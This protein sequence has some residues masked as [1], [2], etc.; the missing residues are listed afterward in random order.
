M[1]DSINLRLHGVN[2][3][4]L[5][6]LEIIKAQN[7]NTSIMKLPEHFEL[8]Q[9]I[10][11][12]KG[13][14]FS[15][16]KTF[17]KEISTNS[18]LTDEEFLNSHTSKQTHDYRLSLNK[19]KFV[20]GDIEKIYNL[21]VRGKYSLNSQS[22]HVVFNVNLNAGYIDFFFSIPKYLYSHQ[23]AQFIPQIN[24]SSF[25]KFT[26][27]LHS[28]N[29]Q[30]KIL[31]ERLS[32]FIDSFFLDLCT[33]FKVDTLPN[34]EYIEITRLDLCYNQYFNSKHDALLY[35]EEQKKISKRKSSSKSKTENDE[36][37]S[38]KNFASAITIGLGKGKYFKIY[39]KGSEYISSTG[40]YKKHRQEN[41]FY[42]DNMQ[43]YRESETF[44]NHSSFIKDYFHQNVYQENFMDNYFSVPTDDFIRK[45][46]KLLSKHM[47]KDM[48]FKTHFYK[49]E[50]DK[51]L[52]YELSLSSD[53]VSRLY[54]SKVFRKSCPIHKE[55]VKIYNHVKR[56]DNRKESYK[57]QIT[58][59]E[60]KIY[61]NLHQFYSRKI[62]LVLSVSP[63]VKR[64]LTYGKYSYNENT[65]NYSIKKIYGVL[66]KGSVLE[67]KDIGHFDKTILSHMVREFKTYIN[68]FQVKEL[69]PYETFVTQ[70]KQFN[71]TVKDRVDSYN[72]LHSYKTT[73]LHG[74]PIIKN[75]KII[76]YATELLSDSKKTELGLKKI[77]PIM[78]FTFYK[79][80]I[81]SK[82]TM[83][84]I[85]EELG[86]DKY[87]FSR[88]KK[89][90]AYFNVHEQSINVSLPIKPKTDFSEYYFLTNSSLYQSKF[91]TNSI[92][93]TF[94]TKIIQDYFGKHSIHKTEIYA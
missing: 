80:L 66:G 82:M 94:D 33:K 29:F 5:N 70:I 91:Y 7:E 77:N 49:K 47:L 19:Q 26:Y 93:S 67:N 60:Q 16:T 14:T 46:R 8:Y 37:K 41:N 44:K 81:D 86:L 45:Q 74:K 13:K 88:R 65:N 22:Y 23:L 39:H 64:F 84:Q 83:S 59:N 43:K 11:S 10:L 9:K 32:D 56:I 68:E 73:D 92:Q 42:Y 76:K 2:Q 62:G 12:Y 61:K 24:S 50:M 15:V 75:R 27:K 4:K 71:K 63:Q 89:I 48:K 17:N 18:S 55:H 90:L 28:F 6:N 35:L 34:Y 79:L 72:K 31:H 36:D 78:I 69:K 30:S 87:A 3:E 1:I 85:K 53:F 51:I 21:N 57:Y 25:K 40:D 52:R 58:E 54:K 38:T 20:D